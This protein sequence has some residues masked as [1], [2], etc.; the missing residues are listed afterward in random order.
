MDPLSMYEFCAISGE[1]KKHLLEG[2]KIKYVRFTLDNRTGDIFTITFEH[3]NFHTTVFTTVNRE[4][5]INK[6][7][8]EEIMDWLNECS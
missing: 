8:Y 7:L 1:L 5:T 4:D 3:L 6:S 2:K